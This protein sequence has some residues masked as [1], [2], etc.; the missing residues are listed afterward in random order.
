MNGREAVLGDLKYEIGDGMKMTEPEK[1]DFGDEKNN[2]DSG[3][4][5]SDLES[6]EACINVR[7][8][9]IVE[10]GMARKSST[11]ASSNRGIPPQSIATA[12]ARQANCTTQSG[13][14]TRLDQGE[15][16]MMAAFSFLLALLY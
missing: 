16:R 11:Y 13:T 14:R 5:R 2:R 1:Y 3:E 9:C 7:P 8:R 4:K 15:L 10:G 6:P 12:I